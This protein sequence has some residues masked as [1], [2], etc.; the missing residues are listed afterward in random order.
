MLLG[1]TVSA[2]SLVFG[3]LLL[4]GWLLHFT[5]PDQFRVTF[6]VVLLLMGIYRFVLTRTKAKQWADEQQESE[7]PR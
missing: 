2:V 7:S 1:Y 3:I 5:M 6:G 4:T